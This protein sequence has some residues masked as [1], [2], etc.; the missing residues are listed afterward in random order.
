MKIISI[1]VNMTA[2]ESD[3]LVNGSIFWR[4]HHGFLIQ[5]DRWKSNLNV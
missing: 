2:V 4:I 3:N 1:G 5:I